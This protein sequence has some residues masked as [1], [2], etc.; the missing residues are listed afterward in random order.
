MKFK[1]NNESRSRTCKKREQS[2]GL[3]VGSARS[4]S[5]N[6]HRSDGAQ[7]RKSK[8]AN[9]KEK[10]Y[11]VKQSQPKGESQHKP[12]RSFSKDPRKAEKIALSPSRDRPEVEDPSIIRA[13][14]RDM[15]DP[16]TVSAKTNTSEDGKRKPRKII[17][18][19]SIIECGPVLPC[20]ERPNRV[21]D[22]HFRDLLL[23]SGLIKPGQL[24]F[25]SMDNNAT[26]GSLKRLKASLDRRGT[27]TDEKLYAF[28]EANKHLSYK[29][30]QEKLEHFKAL[31]QKFLESHE[32][33]TI[34]T[35][36]QV[37]IMDYTISRAVDD[38]TTQVLTSPYQFKTTWDSLKASPAA[39]KA[40]RALIRTSVSECSTPQNTRKSVLGKRLKSALK[41]AAKVVNTAF[42][43]QTA[44]TPIV[45]SASH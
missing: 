18:D 28:L 13:S 44:F 33:G 2:E 37:R 20:V 25:G 4:T 38:I 31:S 29:T 3:I 5:D 21:L 12:K 42:A 14:L 40:N 32:N 1:K 8:N 23:R 26:N 10:R 9:R 16:D 22:T 6:N 27:P 35:L 19:E 30:R 41:T 7:P 36:H 34:P 24:D 45:A 43:K 11:G 39:C 17:F 15:K